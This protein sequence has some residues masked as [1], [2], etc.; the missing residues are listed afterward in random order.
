MDGNLNDRKLFF[1]AEKLLWT[2]MP[3][4]M[5]IRFGPLEDSQQDTICQ[6]M[7]PE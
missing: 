5:P 4:P 6:K 7:A 2:L 3:M 1:L